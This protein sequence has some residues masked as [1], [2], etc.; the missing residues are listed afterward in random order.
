[1]LLGYAI[2]MDKRDGA[3]I[4]IR[5]GTAYNIKKRH[6]WQLAPSI[7][8]K[9]E[10]KASPWMAP[11]TSIARFNKL[12]SEDRTPATL[13]KKISEKTLDSS[14]GVLLLDSIS[15]IDLHVNGISG[16]N[17]SFFWLHSNIYMS[18]ESKFL[19]PTEVVAFTSF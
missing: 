17:Q 15:R 7:I 3:Y 11:G 1:M 12:N 5:V 13:R 8:S 9:L 6:S 4:N 2:F 14:I 18:S 16:F 19:I 10:S